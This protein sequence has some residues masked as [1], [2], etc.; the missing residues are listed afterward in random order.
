[1]KIVTIIGAYNSVTLVYDTYNPETGAGNLPTYVWADQLGKRNYA[2]ETSMFIYNGDYL[3]FREVTLTY[4][5][6]SSLVNRIGMKGLSLSLSGQN[7][8]YLTECKHIATPEYGRNTW[9]NY[10]LPRTVIC[11]INLTF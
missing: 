8:G 10:R 11:G 3:A 2:R 4:A 5:L 1:M 6:P 9:G 7:L